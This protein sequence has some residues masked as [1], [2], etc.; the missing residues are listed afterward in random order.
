MRGKFTFFCSLAISL[1]YNRPKFCPNATW[2]PNAETFA[3]ESIVGA[4]PSGIHITPDNTIYVIDR[5]G[6]R[7]RTWVNGNTPGITLQN[8]W[9]DPHSLFASTDNYLYVDSGKSNEIVKISFTPM[10]MSPVL[11]VQVTGTCRGIF[12]DIED[13]LYCSLY[14][15]QQVVKQSLNLSASTARTVAGNGTGGALP[16][17]L[18][19]P[20]GIFVD[21]NFTLYV[22]DFDNSRIQR[23]FPDDPNGTT[24]AGST[25]T[26]VLSYPTCVILDADG[27]LFI[28]DTDNNR[29]VASDL[30]GFRCL[31]GCSKVAGNASD[32]LYYPWILSFDSYGN[33]FVTDRYNHRVQK[34]HLATNSCGEH[35]K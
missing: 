5:T 14:D 15:H 13:S 31:V 19:G 25:S 4:N 17:M 24:V 2:N 30:Y 35:P 18:Q 27:F 23:F 1:S 10:G 29:I 6:S 32:Q 22:A 7:I 33:M 21:T 34:F 28:V 20:W 9:T 11:N 3:D 16:N 8:N 26:I 12:I